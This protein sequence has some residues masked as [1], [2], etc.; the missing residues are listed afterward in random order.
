MKTTAAERMARIETC[1]EYIKQGIEETNTKLDK[2]IDCADKKYA[3]REELDSVQQ[4]FNKYT[5]NAQSWI[6]TLM[7]W[8]ISTASLIILIIVTVKNWG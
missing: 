2:F 7:P 4:Q 5:E 8:F 3:T 6:R 1:I